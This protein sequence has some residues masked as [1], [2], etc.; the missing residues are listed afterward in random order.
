MLLDLISSKCTFPQIEQGVRKIPDFKKSC[1]WNG[2]VSHANTDQSVWMKIEKVNSKKRDFFLLATGL[3]LHSSWTYFEDFFCGSNELLYGPVWLS[4]MSGEVSGKRTSF[5]GTGFNL[6][7]GL[8][9][10]D[11]V[12]GYV[13]QIPISNLRFESGS[14]CDPMGCSQKG[15]VWGKNSPRKKWAVPWC[16]GYPAS[17]C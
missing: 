17:F 14:R 7:Q 12:S 15:C 13:A 1:N 10:G 9:R 2:T 8:D 6:S 3:H 11:S 5:V 4:E 16:K